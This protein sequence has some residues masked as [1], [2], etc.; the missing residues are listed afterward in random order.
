MRFLIVLI[1]ILLTGCVTTEGHLIAEFVGTN[2]ENLKQLSDNMTK[3][4][5]LKIMNQETRKFP[6]IR[7]LRNPYYEETLKAENKTFEVLYY[8]TRIVHFDGE[9]T[10]NELTPVVFEGGEYAGR[11]W[12]FFYYIV[13]K[14]KIQ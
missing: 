14:Y 4:E 5:V 8:Y 10:N 12:E 1:S 2:H 7:S 11:G 9:V 6:E 13:E 3:Y